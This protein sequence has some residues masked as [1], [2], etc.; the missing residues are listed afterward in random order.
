WEQL[1]TLLAV[2]ADQGDVL[3][4]ERGDEVALIDRLPGLRSPQG[5]RVGHGSVVAVVDGPV[6]TQGDRDPHRSGVDHG[7]HLHALEHVVA[8]H[9]QLDYTRA[10]LTR[11]HA[12]HGE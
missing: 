3:R 12:V 6:F 7:R 2:N 1:D 9:A 4:R 10:Q 8:G 5:E 11:G